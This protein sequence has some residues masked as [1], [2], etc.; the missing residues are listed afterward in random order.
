MEPDIDLAEAFLS[1]IRKVKAERPL[2]FWG[3]LAGFAATAIMELIDL[4]GKL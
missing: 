4:A 1:A 3:G 2:L